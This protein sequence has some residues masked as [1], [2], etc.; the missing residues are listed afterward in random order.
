MRGIAVLMAAILVLMAAC[1][2][3]EKPPT[4]RWIGNYESQEVMVDARLEILPDGS[5]RVSAPNITDVGDVG[6]SDRQIMHRRLADEL[7]QT[8]YKVDPRKMDFDGRTF[9][10]PG[11]VAPQMEWDPQIKRMRLVFYFGMHKSIRID[12]QPSADFSDDPWRQ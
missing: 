3:Q 7:D 6:D 2:R 8:W 1:T 10:K 12:M 4:G 5:V 9:R 11:G